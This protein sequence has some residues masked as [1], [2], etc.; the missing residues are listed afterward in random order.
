MP[1]AITNYLVNTPSLRSPLYYLTWGL[2]YASYALSPGLITVLQLVVL[3]LTWG[4]PRLELATESFRI[5]VQRSSW[6]TEGFRDEFVDPSAPPAEWPSWLKTTGNA[7]DVRWMGSSA[8]ARV[9]GAVKGMGGWVGLGGGSAPLQPTAAI[10]PIAP[11]HPV[12]SA[13]SPRPLSYRNPAMP[14]VP[15]STVGQSI[16]F[17]AIGGGAGRASSFRSVPLGPVAGSVR[18]RAS[19]PFTPRGD[20]PS[21]HED[22]RG[23]VW[24]GSGWK[25]A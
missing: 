22:D 5:R 25:Q 2:Y 16:P 12:P 8:W 3:A 6:A 19:N 24:N 11:Y 23:S 17:S 13:Y 20:V 21:E 14:V 4:L 7:L 9:S 10:Q 1:L 15:A 18:S